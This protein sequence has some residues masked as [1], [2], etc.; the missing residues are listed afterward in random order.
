MSI[1]IY[2]DVHVP[3]PVVDGVRARGVDVLTAQED[4]QRAAPDADL[5]RRAAA[6]GRV[7]VSQD[8]DMLALATAFQNTGTDFS[9][10][11][12]AH[13]L[14]VTIG[15]SVNDLEL[16]CLAEDPPYMRNRVE[17]LPLR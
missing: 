14:R 7:M 12:Y 9:G 16:I 1:P 15:Q 2:A 13:Q 11:I 17:W 4:G 10:L 5:L 6:L 3:A 8:E